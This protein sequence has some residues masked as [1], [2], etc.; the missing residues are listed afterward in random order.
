MGIF[1]P[2]NAMSMLLLALLIY[3]TLL[4]IL[5]FL[6]QLFNTKYLKWSIGK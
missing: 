5:Y 4:T 6:I 2:D 1:T 3:V